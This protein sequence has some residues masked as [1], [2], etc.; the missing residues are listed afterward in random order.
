MGT[1]HFLNLASPE[2]A[3]SAKSGN[4]AASGKSGGCPQA[5]D[6]R[7][8]SMLGERPS[9]SLETEGPSH[10]ATPRKFSHTVSLRKREVHPI[11]GAPVSCLRLR[12]EDPFL[13]H[14]RIS[15]S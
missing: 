6:L 3:P 14:G 15:P 11:Q 13:F 5:E 10:P 7:A 9:T 2:G 1:G 4:T 8:I 12:A